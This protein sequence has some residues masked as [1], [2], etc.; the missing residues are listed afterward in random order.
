MEAFQTIVL[1][2]CIIILIVTLV[3]IG[4]ALRNTNSDQQWP[5]MIPEC[6]DYWELDQ[7][8]NRCVNT[9]NLGN[10]NLRNMNFNVPLYS[11]EQGKCE[12]YKW[13]T[14]CGISWDGIT[15]GVKNPCY[16]S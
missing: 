12:K 14:R 5:P 10:C 2:S 1:I 3:V 7:S 8:R 11:G 15:Y 4:L 13:A 16:Q 9:K 6:P